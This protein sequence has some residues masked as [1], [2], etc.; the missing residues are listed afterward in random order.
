MDSAS[1]TI[2]SLFE[3]DAGYYIDECLSAGHVL[4]D[5]ETIEDLSRGPIQKA[6]GYYSS[7]AAA[8]HLHAE[9]LPIGFHVLRAPIPVLEE[10]PNFCKYY[11]TTDR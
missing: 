3:G 4:Q 10:Y 5:R 2:G 6:A 8:L 1:P 9:Q 7:L 11:S